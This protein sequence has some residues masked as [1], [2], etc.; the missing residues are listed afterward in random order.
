[1]HSCH[2]A[3]H[4]MLHHTVIALQTTEFATQEV[5]HL[6]LVQVFEALSIEGFK[7]L[8]FL[9]E[10]QAHEG[11]EVE[12]EGR[13]SLTA[14][15][16]V[17]RTFQRDAGQHARR[18]DAL[19]GTR[20]PVAGYEAAVQDVV[21]RMLH[22]CQRLR[23]IVV[24]VVNVQVVV[25]HRLAGTFREQ[26]VVDKRLRRLRGEL[27]HHA[28]RCV[29]IH[30]CI[31]ASDVVVLHIDDIQK[32][33]ARLCTTGHRTLVAV[34]DILLCHILAARLHQLNLYG[35]LNLLDAHLFSS[36]CCNSVSNLL[37]Q[38]LVLTLLG[39]EHGLADGGHDFLFIE[40]D[41]SSVALLNGLYHDEY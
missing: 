32:H 39:S 11:S 23:G 33:I 13:D 3:V 10:R 2:C 5:A 31:L 29:G 27:H 20:C 7:V 24:L 22:T 40:A 15:H 25:F 6:Q 38:S 12:I 36:A 8:Q 30:V 28:C 41:N 9:L 26:I 4:S 16:L 34:G 19:G 21:Q 35:V 37:Q 1:M 14:V 17:L 18:L